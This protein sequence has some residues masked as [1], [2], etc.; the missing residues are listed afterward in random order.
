LKK[1]SPFSTNLQSVQTVKNI[2]LVG[3]QG[4][5]NVADSLLKAC[6]RLGVRGSLQDVR[7]AYG[8]SNLLRRFA[9]HLFSKRPPRWFWFQKEVLKKAEKIKPQLLLT[10]G[11]TPLSEKTLLI[12]KNITNCLVHYS[13]DDPWNPRQKAS[14]F[15]SGLRQYQIIYSTRLANATNFKAAG[16]GNVF[17]LP[18]GYED[19]LYFQEQKPKQE[20]P[21]VFF[22]GGADADRFPLLRQLKNNQ[23]PLCLYGDYWE[24]DPTL[25]VFHLGRADAE[26][27]RNEAAECM[28]SL[29]LVRR[30]NRDG[31]AMRSFE[32]PACGACCVAED[33]EEHREM[34]GPDGEAVLYFRT[35]EELMRRVREAF[36]N[37]ELRQRLRRN[38]HQA[39]TGRPNTYVDR[40]KTMLE[41]VEEKNRIEDRE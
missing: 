18:F 3:N 12:L 26:K 24:K 2:L 30:A 11:L 4:P 19:S 25:R 38:A 34:F 7:T 31:S 15:L 20:K 35:P 13:T 8:N 16:C 17:H 36:V 40:L 29:I 28:V 32:I 1:P 6:D 23:I 5:T 10:T 14:W 9:W 41:K 22:A 21:K 33:T 39:I 37:P 27:I